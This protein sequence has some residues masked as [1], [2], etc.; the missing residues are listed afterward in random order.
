MSN[1]PPPFAFQTRPRP[2]RLSMQKGL[3][4]LVAA[5]QCAPLLAEG[6]DE[7]AKYN[8]A[9]VSP[10]GISWMSGGIGGEAREEIRK[11]AAAYNVHLV[12]SHQN[13]SY[14]SGIP[15]TVTRQDGRQ[16]FS[17]ISEGPLV[18]LKLPQGPYRIAAE[19]D[20]AWQRRRLQAGGPGRSTAMMFVARGERLSRSLATD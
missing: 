4:V 8:A 20:G 2:F 15:F 11:S 1:H 7:A 14:L 6:V 12:F 3:L 16:I 9:S 18:Y 19:I 13:G 17:G 10:E 5:L